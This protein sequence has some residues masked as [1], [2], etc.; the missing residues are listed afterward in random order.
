MIRVLLVTY[1]ALKLLLIV[2]AS[3]VPCEK[4]NLIESFLANVAKVP[5]FACMHRHMSL[6]TRS[7]RKL[8]SAYVTRELFVFRVVDAHVLV[9][10]ALF[11]ELFPAN[12]AAE[13]SFPRV[14]CNMRFQT[15]QMSEL[16]RA[17]L[18]GVL[19]ILGMCNEHVGFQVRLLSELLIAYAA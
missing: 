19:L 11:N 13:V 15:R 10:T 4:R 1:L 5:L 12:I 3:H 16:L 18:A 7:E 9:Q 6:Q 14:S 2:M 17:V 8:H